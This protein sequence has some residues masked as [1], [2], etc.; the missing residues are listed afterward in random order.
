MVIAPC[1]QFCRTAIVRLRK[2]IAAYD[3]RAGFTLVTPEG[4]RRVPGLRV[5]SGFFR[6]LGVTPV[7]GR[8]FLPN[9]E[10]P[11]APATVVLSHGAWQTR[12]LA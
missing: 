8:D 2:S 5:T 1:V 4:P 7:L 12:F 10:G 6:T 9:E 3:V 11:S